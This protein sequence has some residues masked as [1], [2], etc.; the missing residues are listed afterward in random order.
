MRQGRSGL[1]LRAACLGVLA[2]G[3]AACKGSPPMDSEPPLA[4]PGKFEGRWGV[5]PYCQQNVEIWEI[6]ERVVR[7]GETACR[8]QVVRPDSDR[9]TLSLIC[10]GKPREL[11]LF[12]SGETQLRVTNGDERLLSRCG[13]AKPATSAR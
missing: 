10:D 6:S 2:L 11:S 1:G 13:A 5:G 12:P 7:M 3:L 4:F 9:V 8:I